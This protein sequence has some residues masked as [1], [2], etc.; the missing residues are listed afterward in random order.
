MPGP[1]T[2]T[3]QNNAKILLNFHGTRVTPGQVYYR[4]DSKKSYKY[5]ALIDIL[6]DDGMIQKQDGTLI[7][8]A[9][10]VP[11]DS[12]R[13]GLVRAVAGRRMADGTFEQTDE[14]RIRLGTRLL[15][16]TDKERKSWAVADVIESNGGVV[17]EDEL[18]HVGDGPGVPFTW[19]TGDTLPNPEDFVLAC[20]S[21]SDRMP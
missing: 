4:P 7:R 17:G 6:R 3:F 19:D 21:T 15:V 11:V 8:A 9:T 16:G 20:S 10:N 5:E 14:G 12:Q 1:V 18:I 13:D 2:R